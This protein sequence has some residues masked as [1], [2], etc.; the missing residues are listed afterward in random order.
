MQE[1]MSEKTED[2]PESRFQYSLEP[3]SH[4]QRIRQ[5]RGV[6]QDLNDNPGASLTLPCALN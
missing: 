3:R 5:L 1:Q 2:K 6:L 4:A